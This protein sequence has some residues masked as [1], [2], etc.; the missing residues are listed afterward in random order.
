MVQDSWAPGQFAGAAVI[1]ST[2][3]LDLPYGTATLRATTRARTTWVTAPGTGGPPP[4]L[5]VMFREA[6]DGPVQSEPLDHRVRA[7]DRVTVILSDATRDEP[8]REMLEAVRDRLPSVR[9]TLAI[10]TGTHGRA[11]GLSAVGLDAAGLG[12]HACVDHDGGQALGLVHVGTTHRGTPVTVHRC[13]VE[14]DLVIATGVIRPHYFAGWGAGAKAIFPGL[15]ESGAARTNHRWKNHPSA[16]PGAVDDNECRLDLEEAARIAAPRAFLLN[17]VADSTGAV[18]TAV[19]GDICAAFRAGVVRARPWVTVR[20]APG[21]FIV[22]ADRPPVTRTLY[23]ASKLVAAVAGLLLAGG[24]IVLVAPCELGIG[25]TD[26]VNRAIY[27]IGL[28]PRLPAEHRII[29]VSDL[30]RALVETSYAVPAPS[31]DAAIDGAEELLVVPC[32]SKL[33]L[34]AIG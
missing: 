12:D 15:A 10:A 28:R 3:V 6:L 34:D 22:V 26:V 31:L 17:G 11:G 21:R 18:R 7:G 1:V 24:T 25:P 9:L 8:R 13:I 4:E 20:A 32:A 30:P 14:A 2:T 5:N 19:A 29:L 23:Q 33:L 27:E 16:R